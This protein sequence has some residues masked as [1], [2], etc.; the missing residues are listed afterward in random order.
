MWL[1]ATNFLL[2]V[3]GT[4]TLIYSPHDEKSLMLCHYHI[5]SNTSQILSSF[6]I[7]IRGITIHPNFIADQWSDLGAWSLYWACFHTL[8]LLVHASKQ[9]HFHESW[10]SQQ[11]I[12]CCNPEETGLIFVPPWPNGEQCFCC[13]NCLVDVW[14]W[15][16]GWQSCRV[17]YTRLFWISQLGRFDILW[18]WNGKFCRPPP[19]FF[20][21]F[22]FCTIPPKME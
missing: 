9:Y 5:S 3:Y 20:S 12:T 6:E 13:V 21:L 16:G 22:P 2:S 7:I 11:A 17:A 4:A 19:I 10:N 8:L 18:G 1:N 14:V 15:M